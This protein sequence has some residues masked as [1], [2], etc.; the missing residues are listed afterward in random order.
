MEINSKSPKHENRGGSREGSGRKLSGLSDIVKKRILDAA[1]KLT[2]IHGVSV[3]EAVM[4]MMFDPKVQDAV[5]VAIFK[6]YIEASIVK[7]TK[8]MKDITTRKGPNVYLPESRK[9]PAKLISI[10]GG[11]SNG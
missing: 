9:D 7:E 1:N 11:K 6:H 5:K 2:Q 4:G 3:E 10:N 8:S